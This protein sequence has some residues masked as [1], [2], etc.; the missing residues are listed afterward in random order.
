MPGDRQRVHGGNRA[1][2]AVFK[3]RFAVIRDAV[4]CDEVR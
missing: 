2:L 1:R 4:Y 3:M